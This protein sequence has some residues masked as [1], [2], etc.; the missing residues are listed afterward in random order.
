MFRLPYLS[1]Q[2]F[3]ILLLLLC[4]SSLATAIE[5]LDEGDVVVNDGGALNVNYY[6]NPS[7]KVASFRQRLQLPN[8]K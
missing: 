2:S 7:P 4:C 5:S 1:N 8:S 3:T 6:I